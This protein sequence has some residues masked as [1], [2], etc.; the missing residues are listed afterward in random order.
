[1]KEG[2][3]ITLAIYF[4]LLVNLKKTVK[5]QQSNVSN[6][7]KSN[8]ISESLSSHTFDLIKLID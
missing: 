2:K 6:V 4:L 7:F 5:I 3:E 8:F 1:M